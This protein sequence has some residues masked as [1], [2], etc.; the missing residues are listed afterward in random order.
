[1][2][3]TPSIQYVK[4]VGPRLAERLAARGI[5]T[6]RDALFFFPKGYEDRRRVVPMRSV[7]PGM[8]V[9]VKGQ[10]L[11]VRGGGR[12]WGGRRVL[13]VVL[14][15]GTGRLSAKWF[16]Y[17]PSLAERFRVGETILL[18]GPVRQFQFRA[19][20]H[21][22]EILGAAD[23]TDSVHMGRIVPVYPD[24]SGIPPRTLRKI[25]WEVVRKYAAEEKEFFPRWIL[26]AAGVP[27]IHESLETLHF[28]P[29]DSEVDALLSFSSPPQ[30]RLI[31]GELFY[32][33]W[34]LARR[35]RGVLKEVAVPLPWDREIVEEIKRRLPFRLTDA[36]RRVLNEIL[37]DMTLPHPMHRLLQGDVGSGKTI[38]AWVASMVAWKKGSQTALMAP[39]EIL[40]EQHFARFSALCRGLSVRIVLLTSSRSGKEREKAY[41]EIREGRADVVIGTHAIIQEGVTF[42]RMALGIIDE[43][44]RF[45]VLQRAALRGKGERS[46]HL[47][48]MTATPIPRTLAMTLYGDL[49]VSVIDEMPPGRTPVETKVVAEG[50]RKEAWGRVR[51]ELQ[52]DGRAYIVVPLVEESDKLT[53]RDARRTHERVRLA[54]PGTEV[55][56]LHGRMRAEEKES[57]MRRF[58]KGEIRILVS[59]TVVEVGVDVPDATVMMVEHAERFG[60]SQ[61]HQ[62]RGRVGRGSRP[63]ICFL[64]V[65]NEHGEDAAARLSVMERTNDG[66][67]IAEEDLKIRGPGDFAGVRQSG[68]PDLVFSDIVRDAQILARSREIAGELLARDPD[69]SSPEH[70]GLKRWVEWKEASACAL[71]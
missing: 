48:V 7:R 10:V 9:P 46:P 20:M 33:Q 62:L 12:G 50:G 28:P 58:Q 3:G 51:K 65:G 23:E 16:H 11:G 24:V 21:H 45:G 55:G 35:R 5:R 6:N 47:L 60:L 43:Q 64:M 32:I 25:Q 22:P 27:P 37:K 56:L 49:D 39:T 71:E 1:M 54:F 61:L 18:C 69:L 44:H 40:A 67:R 36:Q 63:S 59:T 14:S 68:I 66:F 19:E 26:D 41:Q 31:F 2:D 53:L 17:R 15:D 42:R 30:Q 70:A 34:V 4:G 29:P 57:V 38:V 13:E 8:T 52:A